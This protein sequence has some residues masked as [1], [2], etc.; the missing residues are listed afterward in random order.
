MANRYLTDIDVDGKVYFKNIFSTLSD[1]PSATTYHGMFAHVHSEGAAYYAHGGNWVKLANYSDLAGSANNSIIT[2]TAGTGLSGGGD[3]TTDQSTNETI[4]VDL[5]NTA[6]TPGT[7]GDANNTPQI[8]IDQQG[9]ITS[10]TSITTAGSGGGGGGSALSIERNVFTATA[11]QTTFTISSDITASS[12]TQ[13]YIDGVYQAKSNYTTSGSIVTFS[14]GVPLGS[15]VEVVH[16]ISVFSKIYTDTFTGDGSTVAYTTSKDV[17]DEN[18]TQ[19]Y[20]DGVYQSKDNYTTSGT[21]ITFSTAPPS[22]TAI[23]AV[24]F[25]AAEYTSL[26]SNQF[27]GTGSQT[28]FALTQEVNEDSSF[29]FIQGIYQEKSTYSISGITLTFTTAPLNGYTIEVITS[30]VVANVTSSPV[31]SV[32][33]LTGAVTVSS[34]TDWQSAIKTANFTAVA[35]EGY[36]VNTTSASITVTLPSSPSAGDEVSLVDYAGTANTNKIIIT[37]PNNIEGSS[38]DKSIKTN[39]N[40]ATLVYSDATKGWLASNPSSLESAVDPILVDYLVIAGGGGG[41][42][43]RGG[44]GGAGGYINSFNSETSGRGSTSETNLSLTIATDY[45]VTVG[46][47]GANN[48]SGSSSIFDSIT[49]DGGGKGGSGTG[50]QIGSTGGAGGG[51]AALSGSNNAAG[52]TDQGYD[53]GGS[54]GTTYPNGYYAGGGGGAGSAGGNGAGTTGGGDGG[55]GLTSSIT[56]T[57]VTRAGGGGGGAANSSF[58]PQ[59]PGTGGSGGGGAGAYNDT[60]GNGVAGTVNTGSGGGGGTGGGSG[61]GGAGGDGVVI[62]RYSDVYTISET[63]SGGNVL[64][65][66]TD[67]T[68]V[69]NTK[70]TTFTAGQSG[71]IQFS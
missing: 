48:S 70:I 71:T 9:R 53:G 33:G 65:F 40:S 31:N 42:S 20:I 56:G 34:G 17:S 52:T 30:G 43:E 44:G 50:S 29:I 60:S 64:T 55:S 4:T 13:V 22:G 19:I 26:A 66:T 25:D 5:D 2:L 51:G 38:D 23:E 41:G 63:T 58:N 45:T 24:H 47:G 37:S 28:A 62:L 57:S 35:G 68:T 46:A 3:F 39:R 59:G 7:Y 6:V 15:E 18:E 32:N 11:N 54:G 12:N 8:T 49:P 69:A 1:L 27:T 14:T 67:S 61:F 21:T 10:A 16:F 36:F